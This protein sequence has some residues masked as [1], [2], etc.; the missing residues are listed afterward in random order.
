MTL[1][2]RFY[3]GLQTPKGEIVGDV[4]YIGNN[5]DYINLYNYVKEE[6]EFKE[7][8]IEKIKTTRS[9]QNIGMDKELGVNILI[10]K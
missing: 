9:C 5:K 3:G 8:N 7:W 10:F 1:Y 6:K 2:G 4:I